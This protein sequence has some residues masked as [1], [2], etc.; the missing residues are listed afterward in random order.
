MITGFAQSN[1]GTKNIKSNPP[2]MAI[3]EGFRYDPCTAEKS[4]T[5]LVLATFRHTVIWKEIWAS[6][7]VGQ[8]YFF[9]D[10]FVTNSILTEFRQISDFF[11]NKPTTV[12]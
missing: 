8:I 12:F 11:P 4:T 10:V 7:E 9:S 3:C 1:R 5:L 6:G 2:M